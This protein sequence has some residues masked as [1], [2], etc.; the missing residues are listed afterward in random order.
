MVVLPWLVP[1]TMMFCCFDE[2][3]TDKTSMLSLADV[4]RASTLETHRPYIESQVYPRSL[5]WTSLQGLCEFSLSEA[6][7]ICI[8]LPKCNTDNLHPMFDYSAHWGRL[9]YD[10]SEAGI[11]CIAVEA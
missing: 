6:L 10:G 3:M 7:E 9:G 8:D 5:P 4:S 1:A 2:D 11:S